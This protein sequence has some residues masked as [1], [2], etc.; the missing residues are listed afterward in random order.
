M[1]I[2]DGT[3]P[4]SN[5]GYYFIVADNA[6][7]NLRIANLTGMT[8]LPGNYTYSAITG[9]LSWTNAKFGE[10][11][12]NLVFSDTYTG[13]Y[14]LT[15]Q[16][17]GGQQHGD[18]IWFNGQ[19]PG[20]FA[21]KTLACNINDGVT[22]FTSSGSIT[23]SFSAT[24]NTYT[25][26][27][28]GTIDADSNGTYTYSRINTSTSKLLL[29]DSKTGLVTATFAFADA[30]G[31]SYGFRNDSTDSF[32]V[33][34]FQILDTIIP[35]LTI[36]Y[37]KNGQTLSNEVVTVSGRSLDN[38]AVL[39]ILYSV[40]GS[41]W[42]T[43]NT[44]NNYQDWSIDTVLSPGTNVFSAYAVDTSGNASA[45]NSII[46]AYVVSALLDISINGRGRITPPY[47]H[48]LLQ[49]GASYTLTTIPAAGYTF[50]GWS[51]GTNTLT[52]N[53]AY[54]F[55]MAPTMSLAANFTD[56]A[57]PTVI[58]KTP[59]SGQRLSN[60]WLNATGKAMDNDQVS[61]VYYSLNESAWTTASTAN[62]W[63]NW[64]VSDGLRAGKNRL[65]TYAV[66]ATGN[67]SATNS[68]EF[69]YVV[70]API[71]IHVNGG[72]KVIPYPNGSRLAIDQ[73]YVLT[74]TPSNGFAF[75]CWMNSD[76]IVLTNKSTFAFIM[77]SNLDFTA[78]FSDI[79]KPSIAIGKNAR[80]INCNSGWFTMNGRAADNAG[81]N[82]VFYRL[83]DG[84]W[85]EAVTAN[86][87]LDW[88]AN[89][90]LLPGTNT[91]TA[92]CVDTSTNYSSMVSTKIIYSTAPSSLVNFVGEGISDSS[93]QFS[94]SLSAK[95]F[96]QFSAD[97]NGLTGVGAYTYTKISP[98]TGRLRI[99]YTAP[100]IA[101][102]VGTQ[103]FILNFDE[104]NSARFT[105]Y[106]TFDFGRL[107]FTTSAPMTV[108]SLVNRTVV[109]VN[110]L[111]IGQA[112]YFNAGR[113]FASNLFTGVS[114]SGKTLS[115]SKFSP[116]ATLIRRTNDYEI[117][118]TV[119]RYSDTNFGSAYVERYHPDGTY[120]GSNRGFF[121]FASQNPDG[122]APIELANQCLSILSGNSRFKLDFSDSTFSQQCPDERMGNGVG[123]YGYELL[124]TN[125]SSLNLNY[126]APADLNGS[127][128]SAVLT[129]FAPNLAY[130]TN[131][132]GTV[133]AA[134]LTGLTNFIGSPPIDML[135][136]TTNTVDGVS[137]SF[138]LNSD[139]SFSLAGDSP[140]SGSYSVNSYSPTTRL[141]QLTYWSGTYGGATG[142]IQLNY[143]SA[144]A[145][146]F[147]T[148]IFDGMNS[149]LHIEQGKFGQQ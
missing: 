59:V 58:I 90:A 55:T 4:F 139:G 74:A 67:L 100:P 89:L 98:S 106:A 85:Q 18:F 52:T 47:N 132:D 114:N 113:F 6:G 145:G 124:D 97:D 66:D 37:P 109:Y 137:S 91:F 99:T 30:W 134:V 105:N 110:N 44:T 49:I 121:G 25:I 81:I 83:N 56:I 147:R 140:A 82:D 133:G 27:N 80:E 51:D 9:Q 104:T 115:Y 36:T 71:A 141:L 148:T 41:D 24:G 94:L 29:T 17:T 108:N 20:L 42:L 126:T 88:T 39:Y 77:T 28:D 131:P 101:A 3:H 38:A 130:L 76:R 40:N 63:T 96:C 8:N 75:S 135:L 87:W 120:L 92:Y 111:G 119:S 144:V 21:G 22:P 69:T 43:V 54:T 32:Q 46:N 11:D 15:S 34:D 2:A 62:N 33:G 72:G 79:L 23:I 118:Y 78:C 5:S 116:I 16:N 53:S 10:L 95:S 143:D 123:N 84:G 45:T 86:D 50:A 138:H 136:L 93:H 57:R 35:T 14:A 146:E 61:Q 122:N 127:S 48:A 107:Q 26:H 31:G 73:R 19:A 68:I 128:S 12:D 112:T 102:H 1:V 103:D 7:K 142:W 117:V 149:L 13:N 70:S 60:D 125:T 129:F 64:T 65:K